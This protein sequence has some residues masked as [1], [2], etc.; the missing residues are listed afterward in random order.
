MRR[1]LG[2]EAAVQG[3]QTLYSESS[4]RCE[5]RYLHVL[6]LG[7]VSLYSTSKSLVGICLSP[8]AGSATHARHHLLP[9]KCLVWPLCTGAPT[10]WRDAGPASL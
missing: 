9:M 1:L 10:H 5:D 2:S 3:L 6:S 8:A 7:N 4:E